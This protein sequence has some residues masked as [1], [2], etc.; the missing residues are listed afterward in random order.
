MSEFNLKSGNTTPFKL[1]GSSPAKL[2]VKQPT[3]TQAKPSPKTTTA[4]R[5]RVSIAHTAKRKVKADRTKVSGRKTRAA[6][7]DR[8][9][10]PRLNAEGKPRG[11]E[12]SKEQISTIKSSDAYKE[13]DKAGKEP[14]KTITTGDKYKDAKATL[15][16]KASVDKTMLDYKKSY[17]DKHGSSS[18]GSDTEWSDYQ[19]GL[20]DIRKGY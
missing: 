3:A 4:A 19:K 16:N 15:A 12:L 1:M 6:A 7:Q 5:T 18:G 14:T 8:A 9:P 17:S 10:E 11:P 13:F 2:K 20:K